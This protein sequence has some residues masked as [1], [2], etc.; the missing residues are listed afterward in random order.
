M[1]TGIGKLGTVVLLGLWL[2]ACATV[3]E[4]SKG[5]TD[6]P[7][8]H[9]AAGKK[10]LDEKKFNDALAEFD[11]ARALNPKYA[12][13]FEGIALAHLGLGDLAKAEEAAESAKDLDS[14]FVPGYVAAGRVQ[15]AKGEIKK[16]VAEFTRA[17]E[18]DNRYFRAH[19][20][21]GQAYLQDYQ[22]ARAERDFDAAL[23]IDPMFAPARKEWERSMKIRMAVPGT[24][25][26]KKIALADPITRAD[27]AALIATELGLEEKLRK[28]RPELFDPSYRPPQGTQMP[29][30]T[31][32]AITDVDGGH[33]ARGYIEL[34]T[35]LSLM[36]PFPDRTFR[37]ADRVDRATYAMTIQEILVLAS[38][39]ETTRKKFIGSVSPFPDVRND[40]FAFNAI[41][42]VTT[43][44]LLEAEKQSGAFRLTD[45]VSGPDALLSL[46]KLAELF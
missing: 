30:M 33:W 8:H 17:L 46:R 1:I 45:P 35:R 5:P 32:P 27:L 38:G 36:Q 37:P 10:F 13:A 21:R 44:G 19:Y 14:K 12:P 28:R 42:L 31:P 11:R 24:A 9:Y 23:Q 34:V 22:F 2:A 41:M 25:I 7:E 18:L 16:A 6:T 43:R 4:Q 29:A 26:G 39:D 20:Y 15:T 3:G 40:H